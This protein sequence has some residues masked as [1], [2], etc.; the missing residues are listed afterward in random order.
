MFRVDNRVLLF[1]ENSNKMN[2]MNTSL[3]QSCK[4]QT[5]VG[6]VLIE[7]KYVSTQIEKKMLLHLR[8]VN[9]KDKTK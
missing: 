9:S 6:N 2:M 5:A 4:M 7:P 3:I 1:N 8:H